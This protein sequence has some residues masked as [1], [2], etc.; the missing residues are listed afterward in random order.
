M[1]L[2]DENGVCCCEWRSPQ[3]TKDLEKASA[4]KIQQVMIA[5]NK[6]YVGLYPHPTT[7]EKFEKA[8]NVYKTGRGSLGLSMELS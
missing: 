7:I 3:S 5:G 8:Q 2:K 4:E 1:R 6:N